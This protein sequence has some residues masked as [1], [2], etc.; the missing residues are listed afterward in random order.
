MGIAVIAS[1][2]AI[3]AQPRGFQA[4]AQDE[5]FVTHDERLVLN[6]SSIGVEQGELEVMPRRLLVERVASGWLEDGSRLGSRRMIGNGQRVTSQEPIAVEDLE[7]SI[8]MD[9]MNFM[10]TVTHDCTLKGAWGYVS[11][12]SH[13]SQ[14]I[15]HAAYIHLPPQAPKSS[16]PTK[17]IL[18]TIQ[19]IIVKS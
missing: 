2:I 1:R 3:I 18:T 17:F 12:L 15:K 10:S 7:Y 13:V 16:S 5:Q 14:E 8:K 11:T 6:L 19:R 4:I 9:H